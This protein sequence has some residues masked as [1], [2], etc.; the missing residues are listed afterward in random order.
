M[1]KAR[2]IA[3]L[4]QKLTVDGS[5]NLDIAGDI[6]SDGL[7]VDGDVG[8]GTT[9]PQAELDIQGGSHTT[10]I[11][12][13]GGN[14]ADDIQTLEFRDRYG[15][16]GFPNGQVGAYIKS[17]RVGSNGK[18][19]LTFGTTDDSAADATESMRLTKEGR[20][21]IGTTT[22][23]YSL[24]VNGTGRFNDTLTL[25]SGTSNPGKLFIS[26]NSATNYVMRIQG[27]GTR[28]YAIEGSSSGAA[29]N[30][31]LANENVAGGFHFTTNGRA[32]FNENG[33]DWDFRV[34]GNNN[35]S[36]FFVDASTDRVG[37]GTTSPASLLDVNGTITGGDGQV[38]TGNRI[39]RGRYG[40][41]SIATWG[42]MA[43]DGGPM[44]GYGVWPKDSTSEAFV[45]AT[46]L[47]NLKR[48]AL[49]VDGDILR[50]YAKGA[51]TAAVD[52]DVTVPVVAEIQ[53][54]QAKFQ[55]A[56]SVDLIVAADTD[57]SNESHNPRLI[58]RQDGTLNELV[59]G[60]TGAA[61]VPMTGVLNNGSY[62]QSRIGG[63]SLHLGT[64][65]V[66]AID[67]DSNQRVRMPRQP[68]AWMAKN[69]AGSQVLNSAGSHKVSMQTATVQN[70]MSFSS[71]NDRL[72]VPATGNY[73]ITALTAGSVSAA[74][75]GDGIY[76]RVYKNGSAIWSVHQEYINSTGSGTGFEWGFTDS[77]V[78]PLSA[79]D[80]LEL[81]L[82]DFGSTASLNC[83]RAR[84][85]V[86]LL[87]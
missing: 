3:E 50:F 60:S 57:N 66:S 87:G 62:I 77:Y 20:L 18:Y 38:V 27:T 5:G 15:V 32:T 86:Y 2:E 26:D 43:S 10:L 14:V 83:N 49:H 53:D 54:G 22:P 68:R 76:M 17:E 81:Y 44:M 41:G 34:E 64:G 69:S 40:T 65:T 79:N 73:L 78:V 71:S 31:T 1:T 9:N 82:T 70:G 51:T 85:T 58:L 19:H 80:Y 12:G 11:I 30:L 63:Q 33:D 47:S 56:G 23:S 8:I 37:I 21:G 72:T 35:S 74:D 6:T 61:N 48:G 36:L 16:S 13:S 84:L 75:G 25:G 4:G 28:G 45:S 29:Y 52:A 7:T 55:S 46:G 67:I 24:D 39:M 42:G 59:I